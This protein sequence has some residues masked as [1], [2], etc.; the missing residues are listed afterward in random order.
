MVD[1]LP[2]SKHSY[3]YMNNYSL[4]GKRKFG[5]STNYFD[6]IESSHLDSLSSRANIGTIVY[7]IST[8]SILQVTGRTGMVQVH[9]KHILTGLL[10]LASK[11]YHNQS[12][13]RG[14][15]IQLNLFRKFPANL[16]HISR[17]ICGPR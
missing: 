17:Y 6:L 3:M 7:M 10:L 8:S 4:Q 12:T 14:R 2:L 15:Q 16:S 11:T 13:E 5:Q 1:I 9:G